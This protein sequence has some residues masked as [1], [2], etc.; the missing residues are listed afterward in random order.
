MLERTDRYLIKERVEVCGQAT[1]YLA[2]DPEVNRDVAI[3][4]PHLI[5]STQS[6]YL[7]SFGQEAGP[8]A[9]LSDTD[10]GW[11]KFRLSNQ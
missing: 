4:M 1:L 11:C 5:A 9:G 10:S 8:A 3:R 2:Y 6:A 7:D